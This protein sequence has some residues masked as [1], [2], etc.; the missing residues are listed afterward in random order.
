M[1]YSPLRYP[2]GKNKLSDFVTDVILMND[3]QGGT[4]IEPF[5]GGANIAFHLLF[6]EYVQSVIINDIDR[7]IYS[8]WAATLF[9]TE[10]LIKKIQDTSITIDEWNVQKNIQ[11]N[12]Q[13]ADTLDLAFSTFF[14]NRTNRSGIISSGGVI[15][16]VEQLGAWKMDVRFNKSDLINRIEK[17]A[18]YSSRIALYNKD[19][20]ELIIDIT[21]SCDSHTLVY[22]DPPY[23][24]KGAALYA[25]FYK[26]SDHEALS[27]LIHGLD[28]NWMLTYDYEP[29][30]I[31]M[32][33]DTNNK[34][35]TIGYSAA[36]KK[37]GTEFIAFSKDLVIPNETYSAISIA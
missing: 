14:L 18:L 17:I 21:P 23:Y 31:E 33:Q 3:L 27:R 9:Q 22:F 30:I 25:N 6:G 36:D 29:A 20:S 13:D 34:Q 37:Q 1:N 16:G 12:K 11:K 15:G 35:L 24:A 5:A 8:F 4:Y 10:A 28:V 2:G 32:Y 7:S 19:A 26:H